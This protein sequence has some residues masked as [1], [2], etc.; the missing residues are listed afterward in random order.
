MVRV[1]SRVRFPILAHFFDLDYNTYMTAEGPQNFES[2]DTL[3][4]RAI[5][6]IQEKGPKN[7]DALE[8]L[9][10]WT[11][12]KEQEVEA[13]RTPE[14]EVA[15]EM[16]RAQLYLDAGLRDEAHQAFEDAYLLA[17][18]YEMEDISHKIAERI[19]SL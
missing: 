8:A 10:V 13:S 15:F 2:I 6:L 16:E 12:R 7:P 17:C 9:V 1:R 14:N 18:N 5:D 3:K 19:L 11:E 4:Q